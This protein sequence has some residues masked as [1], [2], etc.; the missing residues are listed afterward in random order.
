MQSPVLA[1]VELSV[2]LPVCSSVCLT[3]IGTVSKLHKL[4]S[5]IFTKDSSDGDKKLI[6][7]FERVH[8]SESVK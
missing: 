5:R 4:G 2:C 8:L 1:T 6:Q 7:K 3:H